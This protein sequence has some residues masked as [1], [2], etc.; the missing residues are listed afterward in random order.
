MLLTLWLL[1]FDRNDIFYQYERYQSV[2][3]L[4]AEAN[5]FKNEIARNKKEGEEL[6]SDSKLL[7][8]FARERYLMKKDNEDIFLLVEDSLEKK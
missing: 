6:K 7:E 2:K 5:Y 1:F 4:E 8:K 3:K